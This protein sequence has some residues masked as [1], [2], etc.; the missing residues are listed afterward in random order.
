ML[1]V[2]LAEVLKQMNFKMPSDEG[3]LNFELTGFSSLDK[4]GPHDVSFWTGDAKTE[5]GLAGNAGVTT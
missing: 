2:T 4:A 1:S 3:V 5:T